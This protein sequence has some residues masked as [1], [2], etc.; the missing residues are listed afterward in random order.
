MRATAAFGI[1]FTGG[2]PGMTSIG[3]ELRR[4]W[5]SLSATAPGRWLFSRALGRLAPYTGTLGARIEVLEPGHCIATLRDRRALRNHLH[6]VHAMALA[7]LG[8][9][10]TGLALMN[11]LPEQAHGILT[12]FEMDYLKKARGL[13]TAECRCEVPPDNSER[14]YAVS[15]E[16]RD[17]ADDVV[18]V[19]RARWQVGPEPS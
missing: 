12:G 13:L 2:E 18:A 15:G 1:H 4:R 8:E 5:R 14:E 6:S 16:I 11:S 7:N 17:A 3:P 10:V 19:A 9:L